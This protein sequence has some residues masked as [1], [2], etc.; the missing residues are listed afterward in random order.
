MGVLEE[1]LKGTQ[2]PPGDHHLR[3]S[4]FCF[5]AVAFF[6]EAAFKAW[7]S[8]AYMVFMHALL[9]CS[10]S[11]SDRFT[12]WRMETERSTWTHSGTAFDSQ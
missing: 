11:E 5:L 9:I 3:V 12:Y 7:Q 8:V 10:D 6:L 1:Q 2:V 4:P